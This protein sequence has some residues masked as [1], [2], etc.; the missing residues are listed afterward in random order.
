MEKN[1]NP[2]EEEGNKFYENKQ[3]K[4]AKN[5]YRQSIKTESSTHSLNR[6][7]LIGIRKIKKLK[8]KNEGKSI[9]T[10]VQQSYDLF[11]SN[12][13]IANGTTYWNM[14]VLLKLGYTNSKIPTFNDKSL[15]A[16][17]SQA[18]WK[19]WY[20][21][22]AKSPSSKSMQ[23]LY[24]RKRLNNQSLICL[25]NAFMMNSKQAIEFLMKNI[26][27]IK[28]LSGKATSKLSTLFEEKDKE[29]EGL[30]LQ[31]KNLTESLKREKKR[32]D[33]RIHRLEKNIDILDKE[34]SEFLNK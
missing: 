12:I 25:E 4:K 9:Y 5:C 22:H 16:R 1:K 24:F 20:Y 3:W 30:K 6:Y 19:M 17:L 32:K 10:I 28:F 8:K 29:I 13:N 33:F 7:L 18:F 26:N 14:F 11:Q 27:I 23:T 15:S 31:I 2:V 34:I 21:G